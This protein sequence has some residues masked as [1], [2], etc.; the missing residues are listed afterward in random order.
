M[1]YFLFTL[2]AIWQV[3]CFDHRIDQSRHCDSFSDGGCQPAENDQDGYITL[4]KSTATI[5]PPR[6]RDTYKISLV[7]QPN[8]RTWHPRTNLDYHRLH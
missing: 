8:L 7:H 3:G 4:S 5:N 1:F 2:L 6:Q